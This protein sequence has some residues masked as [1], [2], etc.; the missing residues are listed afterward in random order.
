[1]IPKR[2]YVKSGWQKKVWSAD[3]MLS[4]RLARTV[5]WSDCWVLEI[6]PEAKAGLF[7]RTASFRY[8]CVESLSTQ[9]DSNWKEGEQS[10]ERLLEGKSQILHPK[11]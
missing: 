1:M 8:H 5:L 6:R 4:V 10:E 11:S 3:A 2:S 7:S 9:K